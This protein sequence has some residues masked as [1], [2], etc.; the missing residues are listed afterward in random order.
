[1]GEFSR[2]LVATPR[3]GSETRTDIQ[4][5]RTNLISRCDDLILI[6]AVEER[7]RD[8]LCAIGLVENKV[9]RSKLVEVERAVITMN[10]ASG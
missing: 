1:M 10:L 9:E 2:P 7:L 6:D 4:N 8:I 5:R 3:H